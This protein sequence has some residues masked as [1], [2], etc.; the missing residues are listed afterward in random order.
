MLALRDLQAAV[1]DSLLGVDSDAVTREIA[2]DGLPPEARLGI[3]RHHVLTTLT[4]AL[5][6]T[7]PVVCRLVDRRFFAYAADSFIR[8]N[9]PSGPCLFEYGATF[10]DFLATFPPCRD[11]PY[12]PAVARLEWAMN[13][14]LHCEDVTAMDAARLAEVPTGDLPRLVLRF[15]P[16]VSLLTSPWPIDRIWR[17]NQDGA[18]AGP[19]VDL[20]GGPAH[21]EVRRAD[22]VVTMRVLDPAEYAL[23]DALA[24]GRALEQAVGAAL[25]V[26]P[27]FDL[28]GAL[29]D[30]LDERILADFAVSPADEPEDRA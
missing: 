9:P 8:A 17:A 4:A 20:A 16:S 21:L 29:H 27:A 11:Q 6:A 5:E 23:R 7:Y 1:R 13:A 24:Q 10:P 30:L 18:D 22:G 14:A 2:G 12:L 19:Q 15:D 3:Y 26:D 25:A 28:T